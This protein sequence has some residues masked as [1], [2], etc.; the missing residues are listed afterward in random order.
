MERTYQR[1]VSRRQA[2]RAREHQCRVLAYSNA[3]STTAGKLSELSKEAR[4]FL[5][6]D[7]Q[8]ALDC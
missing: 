2:N 6:L 1:I 8:K 5:G 4:K 3:I 7:K